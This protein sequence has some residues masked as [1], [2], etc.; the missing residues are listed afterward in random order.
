MSIFKVV[1]MRV[2]YSFI[3]ISHYISLKTLLINKSFLLIQHQEND[4]ISSTG[5]VAQWLEQGTHKPKVAGSNPA[6]AI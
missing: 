5:L 1:I 3:I 2:T 6:G 4:I